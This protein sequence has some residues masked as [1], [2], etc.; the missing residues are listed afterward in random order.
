MA[1]GAVVLQTITRPTQASTAVAA[2]TPPWGGAS[3]PPP[4]AA[5]PLAGR[6]ARLILGPPRRVPACGRLARDPGAHRLAEA[7]AALLVAAEL[8][9]AGARRRQQDGVAGA[10]QPAGEGDR[11]GEVGGAPH[12]H[13]AGD[14]RLQRRRLLA[15]Q[16]ARPR[17][18]DGGVGQRAQVEA[19]AAAAGDPHRR[20]G[21]G[22]EREHRRG[23]VGG[24][25]VV[26]PGDAGVLRHQLAAVRRRREAEQPAGGLRHVGA[27]GTHR[28]Q[29]R[30]HV[31]EG[32]C[33]GAG[34]GQRVEPDA[35]RLLAV[36]Q[37]GLAGVPPRAGLHRAAGA[38]Q[39]AAPAAARHQR[40]GV[41]VVAVA[42][43]GVAGALPHEQ[44]R[45]GLRV[46]REAAVAVQVV[47]LEVQHHRDPR[48]E[49]LHRLHLERRHLEHRHV[50]RAPHQLERRAPDVARRLGAQPGG[51]QQPRGELGRGG[52]AVG[53][54]DRD[55]RDRQ[56]AP[57]QLHV[58]ERAARAPGPARP[59]HARARH[60]EVEV[61][62]VR[63]GRARPQLDAG[64]AQRLG[65]LRL[66]RPLV[67]RDDPRALRRQPARRAPPRAAEAEHQHALSGEVV[68]VSAASARRGRTG[69]G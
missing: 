10:G 27:E 28:Q 69:R 19:L 38:E 20:A 30:Q 8:V 55:H 5:P 42:D 41:R 65:V 60:H 21:Q 57:G 17:P 35:Q 16:H 25:R 15:E 32:R 29:R 49:R 12:G 26:H 52:L 54:G 68:H 13:A 37:H 58:A 2:T 44:L 66:A 51:A 36:A 11:L 3:R 46:R 18:R 14:R 63:E 4:G 34:G 50:Q 48:P 53:A 9:E 59:R 62:G 45:L 6:A 40:G 56:R 22:R 33:G 24:L 67:G 61:G 31:V 23:R 1:K 39:P 7:L 64:A 43:R 47:R